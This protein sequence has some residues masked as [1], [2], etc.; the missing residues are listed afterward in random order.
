MLPST[1]TAL[2]S[3]TTLLLGTTTSQTIYTG[4]TLQG[5]PII[6]SLD[7]TD[8]PSNTISRF[9]LS[10][11]S[12]QGR[13]PY[14]LPIFVARGTEGSANSGT[15]LS[16]SASIHGDEL[17]PV[18][19]VQKIFARLNETERFPGNSNSSSNGERD[20]ESAGGFNG[21]IIGLPTQNPQGNLLNQRNFFTSSSNGF[22][23]N[24]N[25]VFPGVTIAEGGGLPDAYAAAIW[26]DV[27][28]N[29]SNVDVAVDF[30]TLSTGSLGP[31]WC[32]ADYRLDGVRRLAELLEPDMIKIDPGEPGSI[33]TTWV[34]A[35]VP[36]ITVEIGPGNIWNSTLI[37][38]TVDYAFRLMEDLGMF[39]GSER[40]VPDLSETYIVTNFSGTAVSYSGWAE[41]DVGVL[42][43]VEEGQVIGRVYNSWGDKLEDLSAEVS[44]RVLDVLVDPAVEA[45]TG[46][47]TIGY[48]ATTSD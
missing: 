48:N 6:S 43:D 14:F 17:N 10:P 34:E 13:L 44:G 35:G 7:I 24:L 41:L 16:L 15:R 8:V 27:W 31:L 2:L 26:N 42:E 22:F 12:G 47:A 20:E 39:G 3:L 5:Y 18:A 25:R 11:A 4:D 45:G 32:Y 28:G 37:N 38:R 33:E 36:A 46:V 40:I 21:T 19:V 23:T 1:K 29:T 30:H 9:W